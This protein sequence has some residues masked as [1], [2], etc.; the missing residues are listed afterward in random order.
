MAS[1]NALMYKHRILVG[2]DDRGKIS[3]HKVNVSFDFFPSMLLAVYFIL[4]LFFIC[5]FK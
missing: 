5:D 1:V 4:I 3:C 2:L